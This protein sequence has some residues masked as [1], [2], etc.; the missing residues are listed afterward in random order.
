MVDSLQC[1]MSGKGI[2]VINFVNMKTPYT[3]KYAEVPHYTKPKH[4]WSS[5]AQPHV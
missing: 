5:R 4:Y 2:T 1:P 3:M